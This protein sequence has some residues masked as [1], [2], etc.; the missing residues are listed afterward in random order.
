MHPYKA[1]GPDD[2]RCFFPAILG[3]CRRIFFYANISSLSYWL[4]WSFFVGDADSANSKGGQPFY[5][6]RVLPISLC[7]TIYKLITKVMV[8]RLRPH[9][10]QLIGPFQSSFLSGWGTS[11]NAIFLQE[12]I[13]AMHKSKNWRR[14]VVLLLIL[15]WRKLMIT[16]AGIFWDSAW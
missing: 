4:L 9:L 12:V 13:H 16:F 5:F 6:Q 1:L 7:N 3:Y 15:I 14:K 2:L 10:D 11:D 8:N